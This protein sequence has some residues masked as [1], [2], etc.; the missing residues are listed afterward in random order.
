MKS[1]SIISGTTRVAIRVTDSR[2]V[3]SASEP[4]MVKS[5]GAA[6]AT[7]TLETMENVARRGT[8]PPSMP[9]ITGAAVAVGQNTQMNVPSASS[10]LTGSRAR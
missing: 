6:M 8:L 2:K 9:V 5:S 3:M 7:V 10:R 4:I 1:G